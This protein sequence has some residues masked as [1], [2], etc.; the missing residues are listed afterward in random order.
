MKIKLFE[1]FKFASALAKAKDVISGKTTSFEKI[2]KLVEDVKRFLEYL[3]TLKTDLENVI[4]EIKSVIDELKK[5][6]KEYK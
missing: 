6:E 3:T 4:N 1:V 5:L 2:K